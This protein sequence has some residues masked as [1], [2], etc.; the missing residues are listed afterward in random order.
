MKKIFLI[1]LLLCGSLFAAE[2]YFTVGGG[3][4]PLQPDKSCTYLSA[5]RRYQSFKSGVDLSVSH[6]VTK[7]CQ[8][9]LSGQAYLTQNLTDNLSIGAGPGIGNYFQYKKGKWGSAQVATMDGY[10]RYE[11]PKGTLP[12]TPSIQFGVTQPMYVFHNGTGGSLDK[13]PS[14]SLGLNL[15]Y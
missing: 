9:Y 10:V 5:G 11:I 12:V 13:K 8:N 3:T 2:N 6:R 14:L 7:S 4:M 15:T 1:I